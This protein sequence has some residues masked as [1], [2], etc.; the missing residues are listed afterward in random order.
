[1]APYG[2]GTVLY[3]QMLKYL[4]FMFFMMFILSIPA[5]IFFFSAQTVEDSSL[6]K[7]VAAGSVGNLGAS[8]PVCVP[9]SQYDLSTPQLA[10]NPA[11]KVELSC[12]FGELF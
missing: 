3:F 1:M 12:P 7:I 4:A 5:M 6:N 10:L 9:D 8:E 2:V 11:G